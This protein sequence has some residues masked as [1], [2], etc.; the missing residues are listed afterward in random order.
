M[1][2]L[3]T[4]TW[5]AGCGRIGFGESDPG[6]GSGLAD[7]PVTEP[8]GA[9]I[10]GPAVAAVTA[11]ANLQSV[12]G[13]GAGTAMVTV[14]NTGETELEITKLETGGVFGV[15]VT[16]PITVAPGAQVEIPVTVPAAVIG[17]D[18]GGAAK[19]DELTFT[20]NVAIAPLKLT[21]KVMG[22]NLVI[23]SPPPPEALAFT[24]TSGICPQ[25]KAVNVRNAGNMAATLRTLMPGTF[26]MAG[27][28]S[29]SFAAQASI[30]LQMRPFSVQ[31]GACSG[32]GVIQ[33]ELTGAPNCGASGVI[34][35]T[36]SATFNISG[37]SSCFCS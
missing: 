15:D 21:T 17:T 35:G 8:D 29:A 11:P 2:W 27:A 32:S 4:S 25:P 33:Y 20:A 18:R 10:K 16:M 28:S 1:L 3:V 6:A 26:A 22:A 30:A 31:T 14:A 34:A 5:L 9:V 13:A 12:C 23:V 24:G 36:L 37:A 19:T 7:A